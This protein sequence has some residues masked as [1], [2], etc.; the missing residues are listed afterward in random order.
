M[1]LMLTQP[2][3]IIESKSEGKYV[4]KIA[5]V[6]A[7]ISGLGAAYFLQKLGH[8]VDVFE[9]SQTVGGR[10]RTV[11]KEGFTWDIGA[12]FMVD[13][14][15]HMKN[16]MKELG[17]EKEVTYVQP[18]QAMAIAK[19]EIYRFK[20]GS[21]F[22]LFRHPKLDFH[23]KMASLKVMNLAFK[24]RK[25]FH[26]HYS[27]SLNQLDDG[28]DISWWRMKTTN[29]LVDWILSIPTSSLFF[30]SETNTP[31]YSVIMSMLDAKQTWSIYTPNKG[32]GSVTEKL[33]SLIPVHLGC[34]V[35]AVQSVDDKQVRV[36]FQSKEGQTSEYYD[37]VII[38]TPAPVA[39]NILQ[40]PEQELGEEQVTFLKQSRYT[41][42]LT[43]VIGYEKAPEQKAYGFAV[44]QVLNYPLAA[45]GWDHLKGRDRAPV[46]KGIAIVMPTHSYSLA[47]WSR[48]DEE[49]KKD[50]VKL[51]G[52]FYQ[53]SEEYCSHTSLYRWQYA[54]PI[55]YPRW[56][57][58]LAKAIQAKPKGA[59]VFTCGD[60]WAGP[61]TEHALFSGY[62]TA[63]EVAD[64]LYG[65]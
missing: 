60:Y 49:I 53:Q 65:V 15:L 36:T 59:K 39:L 40:H 25:Y 63:Q 29:K 51:V 50:A 44:P 5:I 6:G 45:I 1:T 18:I 46:G 38:A 21:L 22:S 32:M 48:P 57:H 4:H 33:S 2:E 35:C 37:R 24:H 62:R 42:N 54:M 55:I 26:F 10:M 56:S 17:I 16:L 12:Q 19:H 43:S 11:C 27:A 23:S 14:Y 34:T 8:Q 47:N 13:S 61:T 28:R 20:S 64:S 31:W 41:S 7:G 52:N 3:V 9:H 58:V 30:W